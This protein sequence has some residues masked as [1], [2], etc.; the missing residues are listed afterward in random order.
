L[1]ISG[2]TKEVHG[3]WIRQNVMGSGEKI[4]QKGSRIREQDTKIRAE[5]TTS[6]GRRIVWTNE[7]G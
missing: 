5:A 7:G 4:G 1:E 2:G 3:R 6:S